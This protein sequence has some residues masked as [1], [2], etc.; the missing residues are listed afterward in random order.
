MESRGF[1]FLEASQLKEILHRHGISLFMSHRTSLAPVMTDLIR[2]IVA[3]VKKLE[4]TNFDFEKYEQ[5]NRQKKEE[6]LWEIMKRIAENET[7]VYIQV[8]PGKMAAT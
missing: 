1:T 2:K 7:E 4:D 3:G 6:T 8:F 5:L